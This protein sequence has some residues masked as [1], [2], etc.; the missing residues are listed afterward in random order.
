MAYVYILKTSSGKYYIG[1]TDD[2][3]RRL[4]QHQSKI[5]TY[6]TMRMGELKLAFVQEYKSL[7]D[8]R[9]VERKLKRLKRK[10]Y[11]EKI[12]REGYIKM[13]P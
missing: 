11:I 10:D 7:N 3:K 2:L 5:H 9:S 8:A 12:I 4:S 6:S 1:S 13:T